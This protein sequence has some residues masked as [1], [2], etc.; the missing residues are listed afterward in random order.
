M[1]YYMG[2]EGF[3]WV[4]QNNEQ[5]YMSEEVY[6]YADE[7]PGAKGGKVHQ[8]KPLDTKWAEYNPGTPSAHLIHFDTHAASFV[9]RSDFTNITAVG[10]YLFKDELIPGYVGH[11]WYTF[12]ARAT[13]SRPERPSESMDLVDVSA[14]SGVQD[15]Y[16]STCETPYAL[17]RK[18]SRLMNHNVFCMKPRGI[19]LDGDGD[20]GSMDCPDTNGV[21]SAHSVNE[22]VTD[23]SLHDVIAWCNA[24]SV[25]ESREPVYYEDAAFSNLFMEIVQSP[26]YFTPREL[27]DIYVKWSADG[28][29]LPVPKEWER[30]HTA[31]AQEYNATAGWIHANATGS[32]HAVGGL[33]TNALGLYDLAGNVWELTWPF[34]DRLDSSANSDLLALGGDLHYPNLPTNYSASAYGDLPYDGN[35]NVGF[36]LVRR[37][38]GLA[39]PDTSSAVTNTIPQWTIAAD[40]Q[41]KPDVN[42][43]LAYPM[44]GSNWLAQKSISGQEYAMGLTEVTFAEWQPVYDWAVANG[45]EFDYDADMGSMAYWGWGTNDLPG[46][47]GPDE[48]T[49]GLPR[50]DAI[51]WL[52]ALSE[53][54]DRTPVYYLDEAFTQQMKTSYVYRPTM[55]TLGEE[56][57]LKIDGVISGGANGYMVY[58]TDDTA[59][60][61]RLPTEDEFFYVAH[62]GNTGLK[63]PWGS[64]VT[65]TT[66][67]AW[68]LDNSGLTT[69]PVGQL[70][71]N[72]WGFSDMVGNVAELSEEVGRQSAERLSSGFFDLSGGYPKVMSRH[73]HSGLSYP[74]VGFRVLRQE[75]GGGA[76]NFSFPLKKL[77]LNGVDFS[78]ADR[79]PVADLVFDEADFDNLKG[80][81]HRGDLG[82]SGTFDTP[83]VTRDPGERW[84]FQTGGEIKSSPVVVDNI[85]YFGSWD[86]NVYAVNA[87][88]GAEI[89]SCQTGDKVSGSAAVV[90]NRVFIASE[91]GNLYSFDAQTGATNWVTQLDPGRKPVG[92]PAVAYGYVFMVHGNSG[93]AEVLRMA[94]GKVY[95]YDMLTGAEVWNSA[96][97]GQGFTALCISSNKLFSGSYRGGDLRTGSLLWR[98]YNGSQNRSFVNMSFV[99]G[100][101]YCPG[102]IRGSVSRHVPETGSIQSSDGGWLTTTLPFN[103]EGAVQMN[104]GGLYGY[105]ILTPLAVSHDRVYAGCN[106]GK[107]HTFSQ[108]DGARGWTFQ[109][110]GKV[111]SAPAVA[112]DLVYF[113][114]W[115]GKV[116]AVNATN[117][118]EAWSFDLHDRI[119]S[120]PCPANGMLYV[121]CDDG[122]LYCI[123]ESASVDEDGDGLPDSWEITHYGS[124]KVAPD[125]LASNGVNT[126]LQ[127]YIAGLN[128]TNAS[129]FLASV[130]RPPTSGPVLQWNAASGRIYSIYWT[131]NLLSNFQSLE[132]DLPWT[133]MPYTDT[134]HPGDEKGFYKIDVE[135][136]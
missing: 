36:R 49:V 1:R 34:G 96:L 82:R 68:I 19:A 129:L 24:L 84:R 103:S 18:A 60:G 73:T 43:Q 50:A 32:T 52:N 88:S 124:T 110:G 61:Y 20:M 56:R 104:S 59:N 29:R 85:A 81:V 40:D 25:M 3:R 112:G 63:Y 42:R 93:G 114:S 55:T 10:Y 12:E 26:R 83:C 53:L 107:L 58:S 90:S 17:W 76:S 70:E 92:S 113:G 132:S 106:D 109:T 136:E 115:D 127:A 119:I 97:T 64:D 123:E 105:E 94:A 101:V 44:T 62:A 79:L 30:A 31:G 2:M 78:M 27:P 126:V 46:A 7:T 120:D 75:P 54:E 33:S 16:M 67:Y 48:P 69:H 23:V 41:N 8:L 125:S 98:V 133:N 130:L 45:Y 100:W 21:Y 102:S 74:D 14:G 111:Q 71:T 11:K 66:N 5:I 22:P 38:S 72:A 77:N 108:A 118:I 121:G 80:L 13:V 117:G 134:H 87:A 15:F 9:T 116:Y 6:Q 86:G 35:Y 51:V 57:D 128:P 37:D 65:E 4:V 95:A 47:H 89:W 99:D 39:D 122:A 131:S 28:Y 91:N 135:L